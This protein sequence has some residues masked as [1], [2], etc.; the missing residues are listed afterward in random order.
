MPS[1]KVQPSDPH[2]FQ[3]KGTDNRHDACVQISE[4]ADSAK[5]INE[6]SSFHDKQDLF[7]LL[8]K[9]DLVSSL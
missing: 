7:H 1:G 9:G 4:A 5:G 2:I 8:H 3:R 6:M